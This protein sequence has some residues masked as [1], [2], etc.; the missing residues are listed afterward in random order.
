[1]LK[2]IEDDL[3]T[4]DAKYLVHQVNCISKRSAHLAK[5]VFSRYPYADI[6]SNRDGPSIPGTIIVC[7]NGLDQ[8]YVINLLGQYYPGK[9]KYPDSSKDGF[10]ARKRY[11]YQG[12]WQISK[13]PNLESIALPFGIGC[14]AA[15]G[16][17]EEYLNIITKFADYLENRKE[18]KVDVLLYKFDEELKNGTVT[19]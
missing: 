13:I 10:E 2:T 8:R 15:G 12:L 5:A 16:N 18:N 9:P 1:M 14:G 3:F 17:W 6:Y 11:F 19:P 7:G 4:A